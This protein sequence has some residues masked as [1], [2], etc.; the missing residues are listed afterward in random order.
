MKNFCES[1]REHA[2]RIIDFKKRKMLSLT[3]KKLKSHEDTK[4]CY[5]CGIYFI[6]NFLMIKTIEK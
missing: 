3:I 5:L 1:L 6:K 4:V 2:D